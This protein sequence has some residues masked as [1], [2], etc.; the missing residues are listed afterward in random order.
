MH[1]IGGGVLQ[2]TGLPTSATLSS[3][4]PDTPQSWYAELRN[5]TGVS[6]GAITI[7]VYAICA[8]AN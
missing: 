8:N 4:Y 3:S 5:M 2:T 7:T 6:L 1:V